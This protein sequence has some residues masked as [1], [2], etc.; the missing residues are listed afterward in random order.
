[1]FDLNDFNDGG[2]PAKLPTEFD[3]PSKSVRFNTG[4]E[5]KVYFAARPTVAITQT[6]YDG[7][8]EESQIIMITD[9]DDALVDPGAV[10]IYY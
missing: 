3:S 5:Y 2:D 6:Y 10:F 4:G 9:T 7:D 1:V 8:I